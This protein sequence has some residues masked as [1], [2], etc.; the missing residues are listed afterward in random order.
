M[1]NWSYTIKEGE[2]AGKTLWSG[3]YCAVA[4]FA[5]CKI[6]GEWCVLANQRGEG[7]PDFQGY[8]NCPCGFLDMEKAEEACSREAFE[9]TGVKI[10]P[11]KWALF[12]VEQTRNIAITEM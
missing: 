6:K 3:R 11:S 7:T 12:G 10:D 9:E 4:A 8:W 5:F 1:R 2:H